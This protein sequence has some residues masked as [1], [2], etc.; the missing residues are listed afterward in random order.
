VLFSLSVF[1]YQLTPIAISAP[2]M[3]L[4]IKKPDDAV[5]AAWPAIVVGLFVA[6]GGVLFGYD[7]GKSLTGTRVD[8]GHTTSMLLFQSGC[9]GRMSETC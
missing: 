3:G 5:G 4:M 8:L 9:F 7:T 6:F 1:C 2:V